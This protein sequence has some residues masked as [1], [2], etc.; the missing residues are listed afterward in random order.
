ML[1]FC[2]NPP[3]YGCTGPTVFPDPSLVSLGGPLDAFLGK[4]RRVCSPTSLLNSGSPRPSPLRCEWSTKKASFAQSP[5]WRETVHLSRPIFW[6]D[7]FA[8]IPLPT[9]SRT[10]RDFFLVLSAFLLF[11]PSLLVSCFVVFSVFFFYFVS[12][13]L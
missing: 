1:W 5:P 12:R 9:F 11:S 4:H 13:V 3:C 2:S 7:F 10:L 6:R 8:T